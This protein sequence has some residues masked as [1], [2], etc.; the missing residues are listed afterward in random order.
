MIADTTFVIDLLRGNKAA[1]EKA[2][3]LDER[4]GALF[5]TAVTVFELWQGLD[6]SRVEKKQKL[7]EFVKTFALMNLD[8]DSAKHGGLVHS[9]L[10][11][12]GVRIDPEDSMIAGIA[13]ANNHSVLTRDEHFFRVKGLKIETY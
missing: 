6:A 3:E 1:V 13:L 11:S 8:V 9:E 2:S 12:K 4:G 7:E 5:A 10:V